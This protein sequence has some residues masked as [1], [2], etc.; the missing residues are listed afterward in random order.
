M[1]KSVGELQGYSTGNTRGIVQVRNR[2]FLIALRFK[3]VRGRSIYQNPG[4][5]DVEEAAFTEAVIFNQRKAHRE[6]LVE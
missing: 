5:S 1:V 3:Q 2:G 4:E 6:E